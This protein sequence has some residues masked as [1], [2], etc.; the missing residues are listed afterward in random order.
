MSYLGVDIGT[1]GSKAVVFSEGGRVLAESAKEYLVQSP[2]S[3]W[4]ELDSFEVIQTCKKI[5]A[6]AAAQVSQSDP[7]RAIGIASQGEA[8][9]LLDKDD[10]YLSNAMVSFD[11]RSKEQVEKICGI[12][13]KEKLYKITGHSAHT[14]FSLFKLQWI[15][16]KQPKIFN[17]TRKLLCFG[18]LLGYELTGQAMISYNLAARTM[19]FDVSRNAWSEEILSAF[20]ISKNLLSKPVES[21]YPVGVVKTKIAEEL[22]L[23]KAVIVAT[24]GHDQCCGSLGV[25]VTEEGMA[26]Y[27]LGTV[28]CITPM[29][30]ECILTNTMMKSNL[31]TYPY[32]LKGFYTTVAFCMTGG[33]GLKWFVDHMY[34]WENNKVV[35]KEGDVYREILNKMPESPTDLLVLPYLT[36]T[37][38]PYFDAS[39]VGAI[40]GIHLNTT[41]EDMLKGL[42]E[43]IS[44]EM[45]LNLGLLN[46]SGIKVRDLRAFGGGVRNEKWMQIKADILGLAIECLEVREAGCMGAAILAAKASGDI[47]ST[48]E[49]CD[50]WVSVSKVYE[51]DE[52]RNAFYSLRYEIY[53]TL[54][55]TLKPIGNAMNASKRSQGL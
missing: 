45:K 9:T 48:K 29:F 40:L 34:E 27:S 18:D 1:N 31:A 35:K 51:P 32:T 41:R 28:E 26:A 5:I 14:L 25:G 13:S 19:L 10:H 50:A 38:T 3:G 12:F 2:Q 23:D 21:G 30:N 15:R 33:S 8:F 20:D 16:E 22:G 43:G 36:S 44:Y 17:M 52:N 55:E 39:P 46:S 11:V 54:Y 37:G 24:G 53:K 7:V 42:L 49:C 6:E 4:F 47:R